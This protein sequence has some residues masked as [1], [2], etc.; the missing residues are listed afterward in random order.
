MTYAGLSLPHRE[1]KPRQKGLTLLIDNGV[2][3]RHFCDVIESAG[4]YVDLVKF[5][6][7][8]S[9]VTGRLEE[10]IEC[11]RNH[12]VGYFFGGTLFEKFVSQG[13][14]DQYFDF[15]RK[16]ECRYVEISNGT[17]ALSNAEKARFITDFAQEFE[18]L[19]EVGYKDSERSLN[20]HPARWIEFIH[21]DLEAGAARVITEARE[22]GTSG[23]CRTDGE[24]RY[25]LVQ[26]I[27]QS[28]IDCN[29]LVFEAPNKTLQTY[30]IKELGPNVN[31][32]NIAFDDVIA[33]ETLRLGLR[34]D[35]LLH[36][37][38]EEQMA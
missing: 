25:G 16:Y 3:I 21:Q 27:I 5:G 37:E 17:I 1:S 36:F 34:S 30:F 19:S 15:C 20:L 31:L 13:K 26:E 14:V 18:V 33:L 7:G 4:E 32:G 12:Q 8:T 2:P 10:K 38:T 23:I 24:I 28:G 35:T 11:L 6:W 9:I 22:S 29:H